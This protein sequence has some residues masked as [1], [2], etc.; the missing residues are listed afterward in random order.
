MPP[1][2]YWLL[3]VFVTSCHVR[4]LYSLRVKSKF[5]KANKLELPNIYVLIAAWPDSQA[6][7]AI[8]QIIVVP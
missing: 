7:H 5:I 4:V 6:I 8:G 3:H 1:A 2:E